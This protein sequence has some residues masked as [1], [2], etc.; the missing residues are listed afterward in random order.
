[1]SLVR[2]ISTQWVTWTVLSGILVTTVSGQTMGS[3]FG[4][5]RSAPWRAT[6]RSQ[7]VFRGSPR[8]R[9]DRYVGGFHAR[10]F[11]NLSIPAGDLGLR[12]NGV[13]PTPW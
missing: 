5:Y 10:Y 9:D 13:S 1:M 2:R 6:V 8:N 4:R 7:H 3:E 12:G 11:S